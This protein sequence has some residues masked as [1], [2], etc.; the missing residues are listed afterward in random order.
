MQ[1]IELL[2]SRTTLRMFSF[3]TCLV[4][5]L[6][7]LFSIL[8]SLSGIL[9]QAVAS[10]AIVLGVLLEI[11]QVLMVIQL[12]DREGRVGWVLH[13]FSYATLLT[14]ILSFLLIVAARFLSSFSI[15]GGNLMTAAVMA[16]VVQASFGVCLSTI[17][18]HLLESEDTWRNL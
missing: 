18:Y 10:A 7:L 6:S 8:G 4:L 15:S 14:M 9:I 16:Y 12:S 5:C 13:R 3:L 17:T 11:S 2:R 1:V